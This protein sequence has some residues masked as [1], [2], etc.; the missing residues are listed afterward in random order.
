MGK[1]WS[2]SVGLWFALGSVQQASAFCTPGE[3]DS[4]YLNGQT[5]TR[6]CGSNGMYGACEF[7]PTYY[8][9]VYKTFMFA[10]Y[11]GGPS[12]LD[13]WVVSDSKADVT[14]TELWL[15]DERGD[16]F[17]TFA[18][19]EGAFRIYGDPLAPVTLHVGSDVYDVKLDSQVTVSVR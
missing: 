8:D 9:V 15:V 4:C 19:A 18:D 16:V 13:G 17:R 11:Q 12:V 6:T 3:V 1:V 5:G 2:S 7:P 14:G 10:P